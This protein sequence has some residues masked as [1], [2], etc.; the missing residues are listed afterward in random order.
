MDHQNNLIEQCKKGNKKAQ[1]SLY[2]QYAKAMYNTAF[3]ILQQQD[4]A[5]DVVQEAFIKAFDKLELYRQESSFGSWLK[6][7]VINQAL[8]MLRKE[9][10]WV[11][12]DTISQ[13]W[14]DTSEESVI[15]FQENEVRWVLHALKLLSE[16][17]RF[18]L[19][20]HLIEGFDN[21][22]IMNLMNLSYAN[23]RTLLS[24]AKKQLRETIE[25]LKNENK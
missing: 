1:L 7:I 14:I 23:Y 15:E 11:S 24:R 22:E 18:I 3:R 2:E 10:S 6:R 13:D 5:E 4:K 19:N 21:Q 8:M 12:L 16:K 17:Q 9:R 20:L 25:Y